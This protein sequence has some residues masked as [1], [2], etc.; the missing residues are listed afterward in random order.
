MLLQISQICDC[1]LKASPPGSEESANGVTLQLKSQV[2]NEWPV[3]GVKKCFEDVVKYR[4]VSQELCYKEAGA[5]HV[6]AVET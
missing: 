2:C 4:N 5:L 6:C 3:A 1:I